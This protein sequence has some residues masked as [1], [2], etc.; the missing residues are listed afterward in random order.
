L[1]DGKYHLYEIPYSNYLQSLKGMS[2]PLIPMAF[3]HVTENFHIILPI[4]EIIS[5]IVL[6]LK[7]QNDMEDNEDNKIFGVSTWKAVKEHI[8]YSS[9]SM[10][11]MRMFRLFWE[12]KRIMYKRVQVLL[13]NRGGNAGILDSYMKV[14][15]E[16]EKVFIMALKYN[17]SPSVKKKII[18]ADTV[19]SVCEEEERSLH[20]FLEEFK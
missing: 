12:H 5:R 6:Y 18:L 16:A 19:S 4:K 20:S 1:Q 9:N 8:L 17:F 7:S 13:Q 10:L 11:D 15:S 3:R 2:R 14:Q